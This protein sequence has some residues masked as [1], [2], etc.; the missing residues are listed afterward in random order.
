MLSDCQSPIQLHRDYPERPYIEAV[1]QHAIERLAGMNRRGRPLNAEDVHSDWNQRHAGCRPSRK[2][3]R[4]LMDGAT[5]MRIDIVVLLVV[6]TSRWLEHETR[7]LARPIERAFQH[8]SC[9]RLPQMMSNPGLARHNAFSQ[10][11]ISQL[12]IHSGR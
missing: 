8:Q 11:L 9:R 12:G 10:S 4:E 7:F 2:F 5:S 1:L 6:C 3:E